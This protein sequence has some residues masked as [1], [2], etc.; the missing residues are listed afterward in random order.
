[1]LQISLNHEDE[2][3]W[4][5]I[6]KNTF[7]YAMTKNPHKREMEV[8]QSDCYVPVMFEWHQQKTRILWNFHG[9]IPKPKQ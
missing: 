4:Q 1:M 5:N 6:N 9:F 7:L 2:E 3:Q 8:L